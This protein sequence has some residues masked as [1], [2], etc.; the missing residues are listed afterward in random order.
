ME[1]HLQLKTRTKCFSTSPVGYGADPNTLLDP[2]VLGLPGAL[3]VL[4]AEAVRLAVRTGLA[5]GCRI[6]PVTKWDRK[7]YFYPDLPKGYQ[8]SQYDKPLCVEGGV[9]IEDD[10]GAPKRVRIRRANLEEDTGKSFHDDGGSWS[11]VDLNRAGTPL[12]EIVSEPDLASAAEA[13][14]YLDALREIVEHLGTSD[15]DMEK[16]NLRC[17]PNVN[18]VFANGDRTPIV[19]IKNLNSVRNVEKAILVE[20]RRQLD[21]YV[22]H[23]RTGKN[24]PRSTRGW[25]DRAETTVHQRTKESADDYRYF[26]EPDLPPLALTEAFVEA[27]RALLPE[28]PRERRKRYV[29]ALGLSA[30]DAGVLTADRALADWFEGVLAAPSR[31]SGPSGPAGASGPRDAKTVATWVTGELLRH[32]NDRGTSLGAL[33]LA[34]SGLGELIDLVAAGTINVRTAKEV[35]R[36]VLETGASPAAL[37]AERGLGQVSDAAAT[38]EACRRAIEAEPAA[39]AD[40]RAGREKAFGRLLGAAMKGLGGRGNPAL[41]RE[42]LRRVLG[43]PS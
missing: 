6:P 25:D 21:E 38:E 35:L 40:V 12:L 34:P 13:R 8:I 32:V 11:R 36:E 42:T 23:G 18:L 37:V 39:A 14:R 10:A 29:E 43:V 24:T 22:R 26:P 2:T 33:R 20:E 41:V 1:V 28:P 15:A 5:L 27:E 30:Y 4:S 17:E 3:P 7:N 19:E 31:A 16:G 9:W